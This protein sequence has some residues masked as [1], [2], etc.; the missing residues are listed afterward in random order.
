MNKKYKHS[1]RESG[2]AHWAKILCVG[3]FALMLQA[4]SGS[5]EESEETEMCGG[6]TMNNAEDECLSLDE[7]ESVVYKPQGQ[8]YQGIAL[9]LH[10]KPGNMQKV[11]RIFDAK[12]IADKY[13]LLA[14]AP[15][16]LNSVWAWESINKAGEDENIDL[17]YINKLIAKVRA[18]NQINSDKLYVLG[19]SAGG[20]MAYKMACQM[21]EKI[22]SIVSLAG[23]YRGDLDACTSSTGVNIHHFH[24]PEDKEVPYAGRANEKILSVEK[25]IELWRQKNGCSE[26]FETKQEPGVIDASSKTVS[27]I[28]QGCVNSVVLSDMDNVPHEAGYSSNVLLD[29]YDYLLETQ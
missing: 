11:M 20:F 24:N 4:C 8:S 29:I 23:Q 6:R 2:P 13:N 3:A 21:P 10:G 9:F 18:D 5:S 16:G 22:T 14:L 19:Y 7:R 1:N 15:E 25:S 12:A 26:E 27:K 28:Y 17:D